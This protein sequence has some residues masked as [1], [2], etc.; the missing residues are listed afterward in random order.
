MKR[1]VIIVSLLVVLIGAGVFL[2]WRLR[3]MIV[4]QFFWARPEVAKRLLG[5][6]CR[7]FSHE[8]LVGEHTL[9]VALART[10]DERRRG[11]SGCRSLPPR[12][13]MY[14]IFPQP[15]VTSFWMKAMRFPL[16]IVWIANGA[17][18]GIE[19]NVPPPNRGVGGAVL[20][21]YQPGGPVDAVLEIAGGQAAVLG[22]TIGVPVKLVDETRS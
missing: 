9:T 2:A 16:D 12:T 18:S 8:L 19:R 4:E 5:D 6:P 7:D 14:F 1:T 21:Q 15:Q 17:V 10:P 22:L 11:L 3:P 13:G 20:P